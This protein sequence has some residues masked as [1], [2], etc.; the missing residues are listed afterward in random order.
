M[1]LCI[2]I[3]AYYSIVFYATSILIKNLKTR[4]DRATDR[5]TDRPTDIVLY[6][7]AIAA[8]NVLNKDKLNVDIHNADNII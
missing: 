1:I 2:V 6:R 5:A 3:Y 7:A 8:K 4:C